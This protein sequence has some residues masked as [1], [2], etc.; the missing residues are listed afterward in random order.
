MLTLNRAVNQEM[1]LCKYAKEERKQV[2]VKKEYR[3]GSCGRHAVGDRNAKVRTSLQTEGF[4]ALSDPT[5]E[6]H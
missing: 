3:Q 4:A 5:V 2:D 6:Q 1:N